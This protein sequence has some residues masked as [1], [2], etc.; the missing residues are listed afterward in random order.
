[1]AFNLDKAKVLRFKAR[2]SLGK[3]D[4]GAK[5]IETFY[6]QERDF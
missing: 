4:C 3:Q 1:M 6:L 2:S 5:V